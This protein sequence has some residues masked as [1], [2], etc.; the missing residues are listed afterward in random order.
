MK[1]AR[2]LRRK[3]RSTWSGQ[4]QAWGPSPPDFPNPISGMPCCTNAGWS[5]PSKGSDGSTWSGCTTMATSSTPSISS[6]PSARP[7]LRPTPQNSCSCPFPWPISRR[8]LTSHKTRDTNLAHPHKL[9]YMKKIVL[10]FL[11]LALPATLWLIACK[12]TQDNNSNGGNLNSALVL[13]T[14]GLDSSNNLVLVQLQAANTVAFN[15][16]TGS[17]HGTNASISYVFQIDRKGNN[18]A[19]GIQLPIGR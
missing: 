1:R 7:I 5:W 14:A 2:P 10:V 18:F 6:I 12:K 3:L 19:T 16:T 9:K 11:V 15:W 13:S 8:I 4:G 17:N